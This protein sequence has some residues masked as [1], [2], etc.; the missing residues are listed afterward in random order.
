MDMELF[1]DHL[2]KGAAEVLELADGRITRVRNLG[3]PAV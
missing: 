1:G 3:R 2:K